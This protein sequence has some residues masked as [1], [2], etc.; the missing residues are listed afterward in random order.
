MI[1]GDSNIIAIR[2]ETQHPGYMGI[3]DFCVS[4]SNTQWRRARSRTLPA[5]KLR[6]DVTS[7]I[8]LSFSI[9]YWNVWV[10]SKNLMEL[11]HLNCFS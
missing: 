9:L 5:N 8:V 7:R 11:S 2:K 1:R 10:Q 6:D 4:E 3:M